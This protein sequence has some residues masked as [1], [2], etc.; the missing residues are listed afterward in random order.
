[1]IPGPDPSPRCSTVSRELHV[2]PIGTAGHYGT[3][4][5]VEHP[6][7]WPS[8]V[9]E[10]PLLADVASRVSSVFPESRA[11][12]QAIVGDETDG[13]ERSVVVYRR[14]PG[15]FT[16]FA[17]R[18]GRARAADVPELVSE[19]SGSFRG[20]RDVGDGGA[21][22]DL[23]LC[24][25]G[26]RDRCCGSLGMRLW[27]ATEG[28]PSVRR[29]RTSHTG[30]HRFAPTALILPQGQYWAYLDE[31]SLRSILDRSCDPAELA[32]QY[33][34][35][36]ACGS[37]A[38]QAAEREA[39]VRH[40]WEW[41]GW[42]RSTE[43]LGGGRVHVHFERPGGPSG[44]YEVETEVARSVPVPDCGEPVETWTGEAT[45]LRVTG[46]RQI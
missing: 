2:D 3:F 46:F 1:V 43:D 5:L 21:P 29:W 13:A 38:E 12:V 19:L 25:H 26:A 17:R 27:T 11:R 28:P 14:P 9:E 20:G 30:G 37:G 42:A 39:F 44:T 33:R 18:E 24:T 34:G 32:G 7:P 6:L 4:V 22:E 36:A 15:P 41:L 35:S 45:E 31:G 10:L 16:S 23:L 40:G 8:H